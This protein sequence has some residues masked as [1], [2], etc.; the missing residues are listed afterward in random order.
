MQLGSSLWETNDALYSFCPAQAKGT[1]PGR[2]GET[3]RGCG[4]QSDVDTWEVVRI[5]KYGGE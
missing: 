2:T 4:P 1:N 3:E 5:G